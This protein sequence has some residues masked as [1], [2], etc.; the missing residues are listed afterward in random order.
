VGNE[1]TPQEELTPM[2]PK[3]FLVVL[4]TLFLLFTTATIG[5]IQVAFCSDEDEDICILEDEKMN[6]KLSPSDFAFLYEGCKRCYYLK[7]VQGISQPS[8]P[9]PAIFTRMAA[10]LKDHYDGKHTKE[11]H[12]DLPLGTVR[13]GEKYVQS[14]PIQLPSHNATCFI[15]GRFDIVVEFEDKTYGVIDF[16]TGKPN[17]EYLNLYKR[18]L[19]AYAYALENPAPGALKLS[20][21][22]KMGLLYFY[23][24]EI[25]QE[26]VESLS[27]QAKIHWEEIPKD[28]EWFLEF[29]G[30]VLGVLE[31][32]QSPYPSPNCQWCGYIDK[33]KDI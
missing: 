21:V 17:E 18:Q 20:P 14:N 16:K 7:V 27:Y 13:Y 2:G 23:P 3:S 25:D 10:L 32:S 11:L 6:Y 29:M 4:I 19:H 24:S 15:N 22:T 8:I 9:L 30:E 33:S 12:P 5:E 1:E 26:S 28:D 31:S